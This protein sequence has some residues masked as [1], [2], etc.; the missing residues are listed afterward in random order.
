MTSGSDQPSCSASSIPIVFLP[1]IRYGSLS[2]DTSNQPSSSARSRT[3]RPQSSMRPSTRH[4]TAPWSSI[5]ERFT[6]G[7][8]SGQYTAD[9]IPAREA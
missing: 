8:S 3:M 9:S 2:V 4:V 6:S 5:S 7:V 1:S